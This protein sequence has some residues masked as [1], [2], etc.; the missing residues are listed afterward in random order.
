MEALGP[1]NEPLMSNHSVPP[2]IWQVMPHCDWQT[3]FR[4]V[5]GSPG[6]PSLHHTC[7]MP[8]PIAPRYPT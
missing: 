7:N 5:R 3:R 6:G 8:L 1:G 2:W 4:L